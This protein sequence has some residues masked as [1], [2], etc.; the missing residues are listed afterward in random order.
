MVLDFVYTNPN[1]SPSICNAKLPW[2]PTYSS[3]F[4]N[5][6]KTDASSMWAIL[7]NHVYLMIS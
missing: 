2:Q 5:I 3:S 1:P 4:G 6:V 7:L